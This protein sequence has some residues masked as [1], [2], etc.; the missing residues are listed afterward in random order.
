[1]L[2]VRRS[3]MIS[4]PRD[5]VMEFLRDLTQIAHYEEKVDSVELKPHAEGAVVDAS[6]RFLGL[7]WRGS[8]EVR[9]TRDGGYRGSMVSGPLRRMECVMTLRPVTGGTVLE[10]GE[11]YELP[12]LMRPVSGLV[13]RWVDAT[14]E[15]ELSTIK[16]GAEALNR[17]IQ[18]SKLEP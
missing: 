14:L 10:H 11:E 7:P 18:L 3:I 1:M 5:S 2:N 6:G 9:F 12:L 8:F 15:N 4:A 13:R 17:R 16:E